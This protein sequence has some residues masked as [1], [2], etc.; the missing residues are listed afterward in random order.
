MRS[1]RF[2]DFPIS[3]WLEFAIGSAVCNCVR[4]YLQS[5]WTEGANLGKSLPSGM[6]L[7]QS[8]T[9]TIGHSKKFYLSEKKD[10]KGEACHWFPIAQVLQLVGVFRS[11]KVAVC[12]VGVWLECIVECIRKWEFWAKLSLEPWKYRHFSV[13]CAPGISIPRACN[14]ENVDVSITIFENWECMFEYVMI[15][16]YLSQNLPPQCHA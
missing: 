6:R 13:V 8:H 15:C 7:S 12:C 4:M 1:F 11:T 3:H 5:F 10:E 9:I 16:E 14:R 2:P